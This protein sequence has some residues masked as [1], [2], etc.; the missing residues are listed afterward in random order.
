M[1]RDRGRHRQ[2]RAHA[3]RQVPFDRADPPKEER[4][5]WYVSN[6]AGLNRIT[7]DGNEDGP[8]RWLGTSFQNAG[9]GSGPEALPGKYTARLHIDG[10][11]FDQRSRS[12]TIRSARG[13]RINAWRGTRILRRDCA[14]S[15]AWI[16]RSTRSPR[17]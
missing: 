11:T 14:G 12:R 2:A 8:T 7:W 16:A 13:P 15:T 9:P 17:G 1:V 6:D 4:A 5:K 3:A 10:K